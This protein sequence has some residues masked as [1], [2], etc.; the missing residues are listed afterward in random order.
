MQKGQ[1]ASLDFLIGLSLVILATGLM[2]RFMEFQGYDL[3]ESVAS[4]ELRGVAETASDLLVSNP[5]WNCKITSAVGGATLLSLSNC[6]TNQSKSTINDKTKLGISSGY[7]CSI[8]DDAGNYFLAS[9]CKDAVPS[10]APD[11]ASVDREINLVAINGTLNVPKA[12]IENCMSGADTATCA[13]KTLRVKVWR[14]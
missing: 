12:A 8:T 13:P 14:A 10:N 1:I 5:D 11:V 2:L 9:A 7:G 3:K 4:A 6:L